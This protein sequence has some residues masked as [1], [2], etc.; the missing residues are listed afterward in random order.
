MNNG[1]G[2]GGGGVRGKMIE[3]IMRGDISGHSIFQGLFEACS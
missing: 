3:Q 1:V 2:W